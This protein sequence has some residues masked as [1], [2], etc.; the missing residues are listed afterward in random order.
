MTERNPLDKSEEQPQMQCWNWRKKM[1]QRTAESFIYKQPAREKNTP[2]KRKKPCNDLLTEAIE[3][4]WQEQLNKLLY[5]NHQEET[6]HTTYQTAETQVPSIQDTID[7]INRH[8]NKKASGS[9]TMLEKWGDSAPQ[10]NTQI[11]SGC[12]E[13]G[14]TT[15][16]VEGRNCFPY[17]QQIRATKL[18][19]LQGD[20]VFKL[21]IQIIV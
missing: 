13:H 10:R 15:R 7:A 21:M 19:K 3:V 8:K 2:S 12:I 4:I 1:Q 9:S 20:N 17:S 14:I 11:N 5:V 16:R 6:I 18:R